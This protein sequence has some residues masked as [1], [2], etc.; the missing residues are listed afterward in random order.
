ME[1]VLD[2]YQ[3]PC[4][5]RRPLVCLDEP[6]TQVLAEVH[7]PL[8]PT[9]GRPA[10]QDAEYERHGVA[11]VFLCTEPLRGWRHATVI[12][13][14]TRQDWAAVIRDLVDVRYPDAERIVLA[15][16]STTSIPM[17]WPRSTRRSPRQRRTGWRGSWSCSSPR[18]MGAG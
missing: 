1:D 16:R 12:A 10:R 8:P 6:S 14:R 5:P 4:D 11:N 17:P 13:R 18:S 2:L 3:Q 15:Q 7:P 9:P